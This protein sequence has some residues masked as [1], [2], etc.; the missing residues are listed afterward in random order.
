MALIKRMGKI[1]VPKMVPESLPVLFRAIMLACT[2]PSSGM[3]CCSW[4]ILQM[5]I[6]SQFKGPVSFPGIPKSM[7]LH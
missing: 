7:E 4:L 5:R 3:F 1:S 2:G 6:T